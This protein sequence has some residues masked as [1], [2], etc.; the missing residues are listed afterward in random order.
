MGNRQHFH[1]PFSTPHLCLYNLSMCVVIALNSIV[2]CTNSQGLCGVGS[3]NSHH[4][5]DK[6]QRG[7]DTGLGIFV[8]NGPA[9]LK[10]PHRRTG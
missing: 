5:I 6:G 7:Q 9:G 8:L 2:G 3:P 4:G 10:G 1:P